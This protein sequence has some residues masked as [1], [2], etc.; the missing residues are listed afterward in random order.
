MPSRRETPRKPTTPKFAFT[1]VIRWAGLGIAIFET[2]AEHVDR[3]SLLVLAA[4][5][6]GL[7]SVVKAQNGE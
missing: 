4:G 2:L 3:P 6:M 7:H 5:M 1:K